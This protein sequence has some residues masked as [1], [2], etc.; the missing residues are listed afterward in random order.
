MLD[1]EDRDNYP[2]EL[3]SKIPDNDLRTPSRKMDK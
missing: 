2:N 3:K 1:V